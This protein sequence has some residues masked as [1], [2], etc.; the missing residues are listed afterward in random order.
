MDDKKLDAIEESR[1]VISETVY[2]SES[3]E[4]LD[5][6]GFDMDWMS[7]TLKRIIKEL[8]CHMD[9]VKAYQ[10]EFRI[11]KKNADNP[12]IERV[13]FPAMVSVSCEEALKIGDEIL[14]GKTD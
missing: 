2:D 14:D 3:P 12:Q 4:S 13:T 9:A 1:K 6:L 10:D 5:K 11:I 7:G 8:G